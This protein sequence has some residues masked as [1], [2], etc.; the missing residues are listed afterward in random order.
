MKKPFYKRVWFWLLVLVVIFLAIGAN[1][2]KLSKPANNKAQSTQT[3][4]VHR[5]SKYAA[6]NK[7]LKKNLKQDQSY[8]DQNPDSYGYAKYIES[9]KYNGNTDI[10]V[11]VNGAFKELSDTDKTTVMN[12]TQDLARMV[13]LQDSKISQ[14]DASDGLIVLIKD[15]GNSIGTSKA[16]NHKDYSWH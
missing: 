3:H 11:Q 9:I 15:G 12:Q 16:F 10:T 6:V 1:G 8:A 7:D 2:N 14:D 4:H 5:T 13:L